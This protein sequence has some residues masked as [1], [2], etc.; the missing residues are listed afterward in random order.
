MVFS[1]LSTGDIRECVWNFGDDTKST[2][3]KPTHEYAAFG[4]YKVCLTIATVAGCK[5]EYCAEVKVENYI[6]DAGCKF[7][8]VVKPK[9][10]TLNTFLFYAVSN[11]DI[12]TWKWSFGD[13]KTSDAKNPDHTYEKTGIYEVSCTITTAA[14]CTSTTTIKYSVT[15]STLPNC[16]GPLSLLLF[17]P[18]EGKC[19][20]SA[21][22][23]LLDEAG[24]EI[25]GAKYT[26]TDGRTGNSAVGLCPEKTYTVQAVIENLCQKNTSFTLMSKPV[27]RAST[28]NG[29]NNFTVVEP[30]AGVRYE[31]NFGDGIIKTG[32]SVTYDFPKDGVYDVQLVAVGTGGTSE[33]TQKVA[34]L[35]SAAIAAVIGNSTLE[36]Y[37]NPAKDILR[38]DFKNSSEGTLILEIRN[39]AGQAVYIEKLTNDGSSHADINIQNLRPGMYVLRVT[40]EKQIIGD[41]KFIKAN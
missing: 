18:T 11:F 31:W 19:N 9:E 17:D 27:W 16:K 3:L 2:D 21:T 14:G 20:G 40:D 22:V 29:Q 25:P 7:E 26:W 24:V 30:L 10:N 34:V 28:I 1:N 33:Y 36:I 6:T 15:A 39:M 38:V 8:L 4:T 41:R 37:P 23:K 13:G 32:S 35:K 5:S 12:K